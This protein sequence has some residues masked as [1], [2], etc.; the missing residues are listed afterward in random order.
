MVEHT[1]AHLRQTRVQVAGERISTRFGSIVLPPGARAGRPIDLVVH[2]HGAAWLAEQS[3]RKARPKAAVL[4]VELGSGS[5]VYGRPFQDDK[6]FDEILAALGRPARRIYLTA[7]SAG[8][9]AIR[10]ILARQAARI[11]G[12]ILLD[13]MHS[14]YEEPEA[15]RVVRAA[16]IAPFEA[17]AR[18]ALS[19]RK[20]M[21][22]MHS[23][24]FPSTFAST[25]EVSD[26]LVEKLAL[27]RRAVLKWGPLGM[28]MVSDTRRAR[29]EVIGF[30]GNSAPD[31]VDQL[32]A[33]DWALRRLR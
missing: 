12:I 26:W 8:Y 24:I 23:E 32:H 4:A 17:F 10:E 27:R 2:F 28:Q 15:K 9:G 20:R 3:V 25:T 31:H 6:A 7:Y 19:G 21:L 11:D 16:D 22:F 5:S 14:G 33:L 29:L 13:A 18:E 1:R 30:A